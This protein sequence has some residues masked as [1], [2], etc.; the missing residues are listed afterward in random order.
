MSG[1]DTN[2]HGSWSYNGEY[3]TMHSADNTFLSLFADSNL[4]SRFSITG[5]EIRR[6]AWTPV[7]YRFLLEAYDPYQQISNLLYV[8]NASNPVSLDYLT[9]SHGKNIEPAWKPDGTLI[10]FTSDRNSNQEIYV[11][12]PDGQNQLN[13]TNN[14]GN[15]TKADWC[16]R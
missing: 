8:L 4:T 6:V 7:S 12:D 16:F 11:T 3:F 5:G 9:N 1:F 14:P 15:D 13:L 2:L 10:L